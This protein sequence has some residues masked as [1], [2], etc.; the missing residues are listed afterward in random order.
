MAK[1]NDKGGNSPKK[2][3]NKGRTIPSVPPPKTGKQS[4]KSDS[5]GEN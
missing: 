2:G 3:Q 1:Q 5:K 4:P